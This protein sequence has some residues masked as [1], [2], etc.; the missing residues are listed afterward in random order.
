[1]DPDTAEIPKEVCMRNRQTNKK[2]VLQSKGK[3]QTDKR[4]SS[5]FLLYYKLNSLLE[6]F[7]WQG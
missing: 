6:N 4:V 5:A 2:D 3:C 7:L 1:V